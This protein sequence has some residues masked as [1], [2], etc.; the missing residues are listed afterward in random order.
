MDSKIDKLKEL[1]LYVADACW[2]APHYGVLKLNKILFFCDFYAHMIWG[3]SLTGAAYV[4]LEHGP[5]PR[6]IEAVKKKLEEAKPQEAYDYHVPSSSADPDDQQRLLLP[7]RKPRTD[8][9]TDAEKALIDKI[10][11]ANRNKSRNELSNLSHEMLAWKMA[12]IGEEIPYY[13]VCL[14]DD[15]KSV[16][17]TTEEREWVE[18]TAGTAAAA[19]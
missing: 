3:H 15:P 4:K 6:G 1:T 8:A 13:T 5:A 14:P 11:K 12:N 10:I 17:L 7:L 19:A 16:A 18:R 9:F 2:Q